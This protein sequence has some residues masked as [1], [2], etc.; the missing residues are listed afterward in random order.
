MAT[1]QLAARIR[2]IERVQN[3]G[4]SKD[5]AKATIDATPDDYGNTPAERNAFKKTINDTPV[6]ASSEGSS[7]AESAVAGLSDVPPTVSD[8]VAGAVGDAT[9][10][11]SGAGG[12]AA[13]APA[14]AADAP[15]EFQEAEYFE[16]LRKS[17]T[18]L[19]TD[20]TSAKIDEVL[21][22]INGVINQADPLIIKQKVEIVVYG[23][24]E[25]LRNYKG[26]FSDN[27]NM[28]KTILNIL[29]ET[30]KYINY[31]VNQTGVVTEIPTDITVGISTVIFS[32]YT[33]ILML[34]EFYSEKV[35]E[36][37]KSQINDNDRE[38]AALR[39]AEASATGDVSRLKEKIS[40]MQAEREQ[41]NREWREYKETMKEFM[42]TFNKGMEEYQKTQDLLAQKEREAAVSEATI[43]RQ[44]KEIAEKSEKLRRQDVYMKNIV[45]KKIEK[46]KES[47]RLIKT[48]ANQKQETINTLEGN[49]RALEADK[50]RGE[51]EQE[52]LEKRLTAVEREKTDL[53]DQLEAA[54]ADVRSGAETSRRLEGIIGQKEQDIT[55]LTDERDL[56]RR[57]TNISDDE[58]R[59]L[60]IELT[61][62]KEE[63]DAANRNLDIV[64]N[65][66]EVAE[67]RGKAVMEFNTGL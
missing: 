30:L 52:D 8:R 31:F 67:A 19:G 38:I 42:A 43:A 64:N 15:Q 14:P 22:F 49:L 33:E 65:N 25:I 34:Y 55:R 58:L 5:A 11:S 39:E 13:P 37:V 66:L 61:G 20:D 51:A 21:A 47:T 41:K 12:A 44:V 45:Q 56:A 4:L 59:V 7:T 63:L 1:D 50:Q 35:L 32:G 9:S 27:L 48:R 6:R 26:A 23:V 3:S 10:A 28:G 54:K 53:T 17:L 29:S 62:V 40:D 60:K 46:A 36:L 18:S 16:T 57:Q 2:L 24:E